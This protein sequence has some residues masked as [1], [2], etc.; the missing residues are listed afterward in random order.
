MG[1]VEVV[2]RP[3]EKG[4]GG[5]GGGGRSRYIEMWGGMTFCGNSKWKGNSSTH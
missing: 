5:G 4:G 2:E 3:G 1:C